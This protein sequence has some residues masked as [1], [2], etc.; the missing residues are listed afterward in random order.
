MSILPLLTAMWL[1]VAAF[2]IFAVVLIR[3]LL[4]EPQKR[5]LL[6]A[7]AVPILVLLAGPLVFFWATGPGGF[8]FLPLI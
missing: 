7:S 8:L 3:A 5:L 6:R 1:P 4:V 2:A